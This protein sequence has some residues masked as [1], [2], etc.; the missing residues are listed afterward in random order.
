MPPKFPLLR[1][2]AL[3]LSR[4]DWTILELGRDRIAG[5]RVDRIGGRRMFVGVGIWLGS[6]TIIL[7]GGAIRGAVLH[8]SLTTDERGP[9]DS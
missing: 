3:G 7:V 5:C 4:W 8:V 9:L 1:R 6:H 2:G